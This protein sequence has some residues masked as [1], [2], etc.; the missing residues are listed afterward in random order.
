[1]KL[2]TTRPYKQTA[3]ADAATAREAKILRSFRA[4]L[5][6]RWLDE[7]TLQ[8]VA[9]GAGVTQQTVI[10]KF[11]GKEGLLE[12]LVEQVKTEIILR[13]KASAGAVDEALDELLEDYEAVGDFIMRLLSQEGRFPV[14]AP[15]LE[16]GRRAHRAWAAGVFAPWLKSF[17]ANEREETLDALVCATDLYL[18]HLLRRDLGHERAHVRAVLQRL[19][20]GLLRG[21]KS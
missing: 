18:W 10:R 7:L 11:G 17:K 13:R 9:E 19:V 16:I 8:D 14:L 2:S 5:E 6:E 3:R 4:L 1:M 12:A 21:G 20:T 15:F